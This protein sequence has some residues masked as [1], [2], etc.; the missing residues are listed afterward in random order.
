[1]ERRPHAVVKGMV[2]DLLRMVGEAGNNVMSML[3]KPPE[4]IEAPKLHRALGELGDALRKAADS[5][6]EGIAG[7][8]EVPV[9]ETGFPPE[10]PEAPKAPRFR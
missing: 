3:D 2:S 10:L 1:M 8:F 6:N 5:L 9:R 4:A 7:V